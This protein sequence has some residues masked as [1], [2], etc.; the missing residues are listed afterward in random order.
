MNDPKPVQGWPVQPRSPCAECTRRNVEAEKLKTENARQARE[1]AKIAEE[2]RIRLR[3]EAR[4]RAKED[5]AFARM[6]RR[7]KRVPSSEKLI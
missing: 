3:D 5:A 1:L 6:Q 4:K 7:N 2:E